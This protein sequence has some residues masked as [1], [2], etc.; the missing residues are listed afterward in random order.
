MSGWRHRLSELRALYPVVMLVLLSGIALLYSLPAQDESEP[1][2]QSAT[3][4][5]VPQSQQRD[6]PAVSV[7]SEHIGSWAINLFSLRDQAE[8]RALAGRMRDDGWSADVVTAVVGPV[9]WYRVRVAGFA[10]LEEAEA[11][12]DE[13]TRAY[14]SDHSWISR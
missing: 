5:V 9:T 11:R 6:E 12:R 1:A 4:V 8:A 13:L 14:A 2:E 3:P 10:S 7:V